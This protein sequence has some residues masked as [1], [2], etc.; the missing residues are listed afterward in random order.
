MKIFI[1]ADMSAGKT[2]EG[3]IRVPV[4]TA[5]FDT[6]E[7]A[8]QA[9]LEDVVEPIKEGMTEEEFEAIKDIVTVNWFV[10]GPHILGI[11]EYNNSVY[12]ITESTFIM[13]HDEV[14]KS[15]IIRLNS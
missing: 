13:S 6:Q 9:V 5:T 1:V 15:R 11:C 2:V 14:E 8:M 12:S 3:E 10:N 7:R 4:W